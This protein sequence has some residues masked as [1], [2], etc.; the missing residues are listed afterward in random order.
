MSSSDVSRG[1]FTL[2]ETRDRSVLVSAGVGVTPVL[3]MLKAGGSDMHGQS[4]RAVVTGQHDAAPHDRDR[5]VEIAVLLRHGR[6]A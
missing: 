3:A 5:V 2:D 1:Q 4:D 6:R